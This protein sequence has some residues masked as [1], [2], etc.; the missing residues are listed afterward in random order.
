MN[1]VLNNES[2]PQNLFENMQSVS[3]AKA[4]GG[5]GFVWYSVLNSASLVSALY[6]VQLRKFN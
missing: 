3:A 2:F 1:N 5:C 4:N 6:L